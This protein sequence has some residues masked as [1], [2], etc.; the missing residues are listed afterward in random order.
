MV[1]KTFKKQEAY[2][3]PYLFTATSP[4]TEVS[5]EQEASS[6]PVLIP[7][8]WWWKLLTPCNRC[9]SPVNHSHYH[10]APSCLQHANFPPTPRTTL[11][12]SLLNENHLLLIHSIKRPLAGSIF[13][14]FLL[15]NTVLPHKN[16][17]NNNA[18]L[19]ETSCP[20]RDYFRFYSGP[21]NQPYYPK[22]KVELSF[23]PLQIL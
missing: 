23:K 10:T 4:V 14:G 17:T 19:L 7:K 5:R 13:A 16:S 3:K 21:R 2:G 20:G 8:T 15:S 1:N 6:S 12:L 22:S 9:L 11:L 18:S